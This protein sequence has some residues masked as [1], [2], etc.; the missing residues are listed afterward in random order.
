MEPFVKA[1]IFMF[2]LQREYVTKFD[3]NS[4]IDE[5]TFCHFTASFYFLK[6]LKKIRNNIEKSVRFEHEYRI[7][8]G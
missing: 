4:V 8:P 1:R 5:T 7:K 3:K 6:G 2:F